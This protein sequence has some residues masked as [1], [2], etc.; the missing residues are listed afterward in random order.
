MHEQYARQ[1]EQKLSQL[2]EGERQRV[3]QNE[4]ALAKWILQ[5]IAGNAAYDV[6]KKAAILVL[7]RGRKR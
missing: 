3:T 4:D 5:S 6:V 1:A 2:P 7:S